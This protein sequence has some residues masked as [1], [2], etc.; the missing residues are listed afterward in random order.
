MDRRE[1]DLWL[2]ALEDRGDAYRR[3]GEMYLQKG[4]TK[5]DRRLAKLCLEKSS[6]LGDELGYLLYHR[7][8]SKGKKVIDDS[9]YRSMQQEYQMAKEEKDRERLAKYLELG[10]K[11]QKG[12]LGK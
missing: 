8:F 6:E 11:E 4:M 10:T 12:E 1:R 2:E 7:I 3:L 9:S 5:K